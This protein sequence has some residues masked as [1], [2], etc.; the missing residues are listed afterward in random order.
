MKPIVVVVGMSRSGTS[1]VCQA[2]ERLGVSFGS[3]LIKADEFNVRGYYEHKDLTRHQTLLIHT[4]YDGRG[5]RDIGELVE[6]DGKVEEIEGYLYDIESALMFEVEANELFGVKIPLLQRIPSEWGA[7][8]CEVGVQPIYIHAMRDPALVF[9]SIMK[10]NKTEGK[11]TPEVY[12]KFQRQWAWAN[13]ELFK[14]GPACEVW[15]AEWFED[16]DAVM[17]RLAK[18]IG[19]ET[20]ST[21]GLLI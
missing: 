5:W 7:I 4:C 1:I 21:E 3:P 13:G 2:L 14:Y 9:N 17:K 12:R 11:R 18:A 15:Y 6:L 10:A 20:V 16:A 19:R 8:F